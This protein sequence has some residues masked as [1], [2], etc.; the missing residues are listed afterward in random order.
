MFDRGLRTGP[1][2]TPDPSGCIGLALATP[3]AI[4]PM[5]VEATSLTHTRAVG[6]LLQ[7]VNQL[8]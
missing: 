8:C 3:A 7:V 5:P 4:V 1:G 2:T 6:Y